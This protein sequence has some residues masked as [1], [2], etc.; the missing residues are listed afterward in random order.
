MEKLTVE[1]PS[2]EGSPENYT[3]NLGLAYILADLPEERPA[4]P[5]CS[6]TEGGL[7]LYPARQVK[8]DL[9]GY[10]YEMTLRLQCDACKTYIERDATDEEMSTMTF[11]AKHE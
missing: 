3:E 1:A 4:C 11:A 7:A 5:L 10:K 9:I 6:A 2:E 8:M